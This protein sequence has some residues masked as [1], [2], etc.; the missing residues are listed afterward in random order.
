MNPQIRDAI[1]QHGYCIWLKASLDI[2]VERTSKRT[3]RP[4]L[5]T[6]E[7]REILRDLMDNRYPVYAQADLTIETGAE[8]INETLRAILDALKQQTPI[9]G[10]SKDE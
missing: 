1:A 8:S 7:P 2:L 5:K 10:V 3:G 6:G 4:L 9:I